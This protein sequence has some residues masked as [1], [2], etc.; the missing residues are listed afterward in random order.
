M[1]VTHTAVFQQTCPFNLMKSSIC[2]NCCTG[3]LTPLV[4]VNDTDDNNEN[5]TNDL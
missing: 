3:G 1:K 5:L 2:Q 4:R